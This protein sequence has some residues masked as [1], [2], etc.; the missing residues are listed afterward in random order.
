M[1]MVFGYRR[2]A[3]QHFRIP[4]C[5]DPELSMILIINHKLK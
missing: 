2:S 5:K 4:S 3:A 1:G